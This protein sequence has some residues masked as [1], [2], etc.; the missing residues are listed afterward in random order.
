MPHASQGQCTVL[1]KLSRMNGPLHTIM[2][3]SRDARQDH[4]ARGDDLATRS[5]VSSSSMSAMSSAI[6]PSTLEDSASSDT[7]S[8]IARDMDHT[9]VKIERNS[10]S[11]SASP[12]SPRDPIHDYLTSPIP[13]AS[14]ASQAVAV[15][16]RGRGRPRKNSISTLSSPTFKAKTFVRSKTGCMT[17]RKRKKK[18]D[19]RKPECTLPPVYFLSCSNNC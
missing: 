10:E 5:S 18:C 9:V 8:E 19:E 14:A 13:P 1:T 3:D 6:S 4:F 11:A 17:C 15:P 2:T 16:K 7:D 12:T